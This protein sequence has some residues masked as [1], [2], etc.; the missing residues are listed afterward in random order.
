MSEMPQQSLPEDESEKADELRAAIGRLTR[1]LADREA[2][3]RPLPTSVMR[4]YQ[5]LI[6]KHFAKLAEIEARSATR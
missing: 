5:A 3:S 1:E 6:D 4:A 2:D